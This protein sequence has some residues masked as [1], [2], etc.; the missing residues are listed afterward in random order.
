MGNWIIISLIGVFA[1]I[2]SGLLGVGGGLV[3][4][5]LLVFL[6]K[7]NIHQAV[8]TSLVIIVPTAA[9]GAF[10][11]FLAGNV[12]WKYVFIISLFAM[13]GGFL[14]AH[15]ATGLNAAVLKK[16]FAVFLVIMAVRMLTSS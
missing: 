4:V 16:V 12:V 13:A 11:H 7:L 10:R 8:A 9:V 5:P 14:G 15:I 3:I 1:G 6:A 2:A